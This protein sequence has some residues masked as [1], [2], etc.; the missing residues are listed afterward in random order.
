MRIAE[1]AK[2]GNR[3][4]FATAAPASMLPLALTLARNARDAGADVV[5]EDD[6]RPERIDG[7][8]ARFIRWLD[9]V[10]L[11]TDGSNVWATNGPEAAREWLFLAPRPV[12]VV[13]DGPFAEAAYTAGLE[14]VA[15]MGLDR[16]ALAVPAA[17][18]DRCVVVP[19]SPGRPA[20]SYRPVLDV[21]EAAFAT[22]G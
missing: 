15:F 7:R 2:A 10:A 8:V 16:P 18:G 1:V 19:V 6:G 21:F 13:A 12:L 5:D 3:I 20:R 17:R 14:V 11:V 4:A 22:R 9:G